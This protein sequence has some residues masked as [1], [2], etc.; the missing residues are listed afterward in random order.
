MRLFSNSTAVDTADIDAALQ[1]RL[2]TFVP[3]DID[4]VALHEPTN[5]QVQTEHLALAL[6]GIK[7]DSRDQGLG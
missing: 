5:F 4:L 2:D 6:Y 3:A 1:T 7:A